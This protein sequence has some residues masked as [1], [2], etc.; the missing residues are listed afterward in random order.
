MVICSRQV[1]E[2]LI[3]IYFCE[4]NRNPNT[5]LYFRIKSKLLGLDK[6]YINRI[7]GRYPA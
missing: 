4:F 3:D 2:A 5:P 1:E 7:P 6:S